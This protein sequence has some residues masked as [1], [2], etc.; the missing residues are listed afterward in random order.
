M[1]TDQA[2]LGGRRPQREG[3]VGVAVGV[4]DGRV[5]GSADELPLRPALAWLASFARSSM[6]NADAFAAS[7]P[8]ERSGESDR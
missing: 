5:D 2:E 7:K 1:L 4:D 3:D 6:L 8:F